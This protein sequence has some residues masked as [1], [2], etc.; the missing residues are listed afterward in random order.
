MRLKIVLTSL[1]AI[2]MLSLTT[3]FSSCNGKTPWDKHENNRDELCDSALVAE[4]INRIVDPTFISSAEVIDFVTKVRENAEI[5]S[6]FIR[7]PSDVLVNVATVCIKNNGVTT[8][9]EIINEL[10]KN[11]NIYMNLPAP[12]LPQQQTSQASSTSS[13]INTTSND[14]NSGRPTIR[15]DD[16][17][18]LYNTYDTIINSKKHKVVKKIEPYE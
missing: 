8:K 16:D 10:R 15:N 2:L 6:V 7:I 5:D 18:I 12:P 14:S 9:R 3:T 13:D 1:I 17:L 11:K 4:Y